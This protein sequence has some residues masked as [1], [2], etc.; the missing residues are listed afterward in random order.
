MP[1]ITGMPELDRSILENHASWI[2]LFGDCFVWI[3][4]RQILDFCLLNFL[5][6]YL[7]LVMIDYVVTELRSFS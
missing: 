4:T 7:H 2:V 6:G 3:V 1:I 5:R